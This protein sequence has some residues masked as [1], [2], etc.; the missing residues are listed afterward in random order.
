[1]YSLA[2]DEQG[3]KPRAEWDLAFNMKDVMSPIFVNTN[4]SHPPVGSIGV[5]L[6]NYPKDDTSAWSSIDTSGLSTWQSR[7]NS[8][9]SWSYGA[10]GNYVNPNDPSDVDWGKYNFSTHVITGD[11][12]Y[13]LKLASGDY[14]KLWIKRLKS[15]VFTFVYANIDGSDETT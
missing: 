15:G 14:K 7:T 12:I 6:W 1:W 5:T 11:S 2:N 4:F 9:T 13:I 10:M 8:D 3:T